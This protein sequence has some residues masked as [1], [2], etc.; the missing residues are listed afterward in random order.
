MKAIPKIA[1]LTFLAIGVWS[2][3]R[4][5]PHMTGYHTPAHLISQIKSADHIVVTNL[6]AAVRHDSQSSFSKT[7]TG[8]EAQ[9]IVHAI[10][11][12]RAPTYDIPT[13]MSSMLYE[14]QL[15]FYQGTELLGTADLSDGLVLC[16][17]GEYHEPWTLRRLYHR[18][19]KESGE[20]D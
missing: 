17:G 3:C 11:S 8:H 18:I 4:S 12:L 19:A 10:S 9:M 2:G 1:I 5:D 16:D 13:P 15:Q 14:W 7:I 6:F 20:D